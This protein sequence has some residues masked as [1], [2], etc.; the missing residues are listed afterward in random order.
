MTR[1]DRGAIAPLLFSWRR[2][3]I[4]VAA[5]LLQACSGSSAIPPFTA[6]GYVSDD[7]AVRIWRKDDAHGG[8]HILAVYSPWGQGTTS[9][10]EYRWQDER[11]TSLELTGLTTPREQIKVRFDDKG[12][13]SFMQRD[14]GNSRQQLSSDQIALYQYRA[15]RLRQ[16]S[17]ALRSGRVALYQGRW[18]PDGNVVTCAGKTVSPALDSAALGH[19]RQRQSHSAG[20]VNIAWLEAPEGAQLLLV[21]NEDFCR[22][23]PEAQSF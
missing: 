3:A 2:G 19:I 9:T 23:E 8:V 22:W 7:G 12:E 14:V 6:S 15:T 16:T 20:A 5:L 1:F 21:A 10:R 11:L 18:Q 17:D 4:L 13:L